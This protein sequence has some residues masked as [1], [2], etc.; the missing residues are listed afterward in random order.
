MLDF[1]YNK[2]EWMSRFST[3]MHFV[4]LGKS[5]YL[6]DANDDIFIS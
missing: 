1:L 5:Q 4:F 2:S 6:N 3:D